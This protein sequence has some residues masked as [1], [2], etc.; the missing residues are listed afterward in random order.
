MLSDLGRVER[1]VGHAQG[2][3]VVLLLSDYELPKIDGAGDAGGV[4]VI[5]THAVDVAVVV[6]RRILI[7]FGRWQRSTFP[8]TIG[9]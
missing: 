4:G 9:T 7:I 1:L 2:L 6:M 5:E 3:G 8:G